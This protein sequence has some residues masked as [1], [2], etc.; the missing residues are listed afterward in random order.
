MGETDD[1]GLIFAYAFDG[2][3]GART[4]GWDDLDRPR[5]G[6]VWI[7]L[8]LDAARARQ[9]LGE[10]SGLDPVAVEALLY[11]ETRPR[12]TPMGE[13]LLVNL[14]GVNLNPGADPEDMVAVRI[15]IDAHRA[16]TVRRGKLMAI[17]DIR[18]QIAENAAPRGAGEFLVDLADRLVERMG[19]VI[20][21]LDDGV[22]AVEDKVLS[23]AGAALRTELWQLRRTAIALRRYIA[24]QRDAMGRLLTERIGW[25]D[26]HSTQRMR[27]V[28]DR[29]TRYVEDL[30]TMR[31]RAAVV[32]DELTTRL[33]D[34]MNR[35]MYLLSIIAGIFLP[36]SL[37]TGILGI[38]VGGI[39]GDKWGWS[40]YVVLAGLCAMGAA[41]YWIFR[42]MKWL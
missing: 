42:R 13:G 8:H 10:R 35:N 15:H 37:V 2:Q 40:F 27:E 9:W 17:Q 32:Q 21:D 5:E 33:T 30:D 36:L 3:G 39:P 1:D 7:H 14:R 34:Q 26:S 29:I 20:A 24:P 41:E 22:D 12:S 4:L 23:A 31:D 11:E 28:A 18:D 38:N 19:P 6:F 25:M 16:I